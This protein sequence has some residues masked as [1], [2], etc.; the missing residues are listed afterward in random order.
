MATEA[1]EF[2]LTWGIEGMALKEL[3]SRIATHK[4]PDELIKEALLRFLKDLNKAIE[5]MD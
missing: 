3:V 1:K 5:M 4:F 2:I